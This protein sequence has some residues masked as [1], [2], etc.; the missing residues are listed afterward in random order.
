MFAQKIQRG[1]KEALTGDFMIIARLE[2]LIAGTGMED[3]LGRA[4]TYIQAG[5]DGIMIH[6]QKSLTDE[7]LTFAQSYNSLSE[8]LGTRPPLVCVPTTYNLITDQ[9]L[10]DHGFKL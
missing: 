3:A 2:S 5:V 8:R 4:E 7:I 1:K 9:E 10:A 6:S